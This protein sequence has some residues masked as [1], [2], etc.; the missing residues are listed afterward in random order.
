MSR[1]L[2]FYPL[3]DTWLEVRELVPMQFWEVLSYENDLPVENVLLVP[4]TVY[5]AVETLSGN[6]LSR[7]L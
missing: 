1:Q 5:E 7:V 3:V 6:S 2:C 4:S